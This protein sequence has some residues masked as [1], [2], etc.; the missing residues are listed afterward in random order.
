MTVADD[1]KFMINGQPM[2]VHQL[3]H[4]MNGTATI[5]TTTTVTP[6]TVTE[7]KNGTVLRSSASSILVRT[8]QG[9]K[10]FTQGEIDKRGVK[11]VKNGEPA[12]LSDFREGDKLSATIIT[13]MP[14]HVLTQKEVQ[15]TLAAAPAAAASGGSAAPAKKAAAPSSTLASNGTSSTG[16]APATSGKTLPKTASGWPLLGLLS[17]LS[18][19]MGVGLTLRRRFVG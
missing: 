16:A 11:I 5:T 3:K 15:A 18:L 6:V 7:V 4:G 13:S 17:V 8:D 1:F 19:A 10:N 14:P 9:I 12:E 2:S